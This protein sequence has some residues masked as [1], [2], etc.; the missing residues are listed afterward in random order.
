MNINTI[1]E[2]KGSI[3]LELKELNSK[4]QSLNMNLSELNKKYNQ[5]II[6]GFL[7]YIKVGDVITMNHIIFRP[8]LLR[9]GE[10]IKIIKKNKKS[11]I[12]NQ[13]TKVTFSSDGSRKNETDVDIK[14]KIDIEKLFDIYRRNDS[15][16]YERLV[17]TLVRKSKFEELGI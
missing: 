4:I 8:V 6:E 15:G 12:I 17:S 7:N 1:V 13:I 3:I 10:V 16:F 11:V 14:F 9:S 2:K 5:L